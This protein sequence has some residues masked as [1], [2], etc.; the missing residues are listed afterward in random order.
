MGVVQ[1]VLE[2][3][4]SDAQSCRESA[5]CILRINVAAVDLG[6]GQSL[7]VR[8]AYFMINH[9]LCKS[10]SIDENYAPSRLLC[11][12]PRILGK[13]TARK[14]DSLVGY[15]A[16]GGLRRDDASLRGKLAQPPLTDAWRTK[17]A[18]PTKDVL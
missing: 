8:A 14:E 7:L 10:S 1:E 4:D 13:G 2:G 17:G 9:H 11:C 5:C 18:R 3:S 15:T 12:F 6:N 16:F